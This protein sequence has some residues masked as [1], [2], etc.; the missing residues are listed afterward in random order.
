MLA[1]FIDLRMH[2]GNRFFSLNISLMIAFTAEHQGRG[3]LSCPRRITHPWHDKVDAALSSEGAQPPHM[4]G[5]SRKPEEFLHA[6]GGWR[7]GTS[8][9]LGSHLRSS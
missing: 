7:P 6:L 8:H 1:C 4:P 5:G 9:T 3:L 2:L